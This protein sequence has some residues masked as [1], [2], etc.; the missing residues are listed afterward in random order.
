MMWRVV[1]AILQKDIRSESRSRELVGTMVLFALL[2]VLIFS[3]ALELDRIAR[4]EAISGVLWVTVIF[5]SVLGLN[6][7]SAQ[8][9]EQGSI[10]ALLIAPIPR[11]AIFL[12]KFLGN[13]LFTTLVALCLLPIMTVLYNITLVNAAVVVLLLIGI[14]GVCMTG[15]LLSAMTVQARGGE[16]L[17]P[18]V[19]LPV[20]LPIL[21][22]TVRATTGILNGVPVNDWIGW[23]PIVLLIDVFYSAACIWAFAYII[24]E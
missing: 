13:F 14:W 19:L 21:L 23:F 12:G 1:W 16:A 5:A 18:V 9:R 2:S 17:L 3:F 20:V 4:R 8:E 6:R 11:Y 24:E 15:T 7:T 10:D 22:A